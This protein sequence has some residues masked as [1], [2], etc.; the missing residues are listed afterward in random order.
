MGIGGPATLTTL[1]S[2]SV[3]LNTSNTFSGGIT[4]GGS[5]TLT[6]G[7]AGNLGGGNYAG[8]IADSSS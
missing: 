4:I 3:T 1:G 5:G 7:G 8:N 2:G 6:I